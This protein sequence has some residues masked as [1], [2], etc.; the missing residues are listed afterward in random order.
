MNARQQILLAHVRAI[1]EHG[2]QA[3]RTD[4]V[5]AQ[6]G[7][8]KGAFYHYFPT[9]NH[10]GYALLDEIICPLYLGLWRSFAEDTGDSRL[11][12][13]KT[14]EQ[15]RG[16]VDPDSVRWG[17]LLTNLIQEMTPVDSGFQVRLSTTLLHMQ[18]MIVL[19]IQRGQ[20]AGYFRNELM[21]EPTALLLLASI[22]GAFSIGKGLQSLVAFHDVLDQLE[23]IIE[24]WSPPR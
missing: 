4:R 24:T 8:T 1:H 3:T 12:L 2:F 18:Q 7:I 16:L 6:M 23:A 21:P 11:L 19:G 17:C 10:L 5:V 13:R 14:I 20:Q 22:Q 15:Y 9:K